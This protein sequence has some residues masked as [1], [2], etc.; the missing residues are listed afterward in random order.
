[1]D[2]IRLVSDTNSMN[3]GKKPKSETV[4]DTSP[5]IEALHHQLWM[6]RSPQERNL[7]AARMN[8]AARK[9]VIASLPPGLSEREFKRALYR[10]LYGEELPA[11]FFER[12]ADEN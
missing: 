6:S 9:I 3:A 10:R 11:D 2:L 1:M 12:L 4:T 7:F 8:A 5:E